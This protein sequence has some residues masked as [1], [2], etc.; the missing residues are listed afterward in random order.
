MPNFSNARVGDK[1]Y[2]LEWGECEIIKIKDDSYPIVVGVD[3]E[4]VETYTIKGFRLENHT[5]PSLFW[6]KPAISDPPP[7]RRM[8]KKTLWVGV[9]NLLSPGFY[10]T[11]T[12]CED[13][14]KLETFY[15]HGIHPIEIDVE[16]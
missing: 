7:P 10:D 16:E 3:G 14:D 11:S 1:V 9:G 15:K 13:R 2:S 8:V 4:V 6:S 5:L 12:A